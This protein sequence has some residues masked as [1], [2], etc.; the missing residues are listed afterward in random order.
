MYPRIL[1]VDGACGTGDLSRI[2]LKK[3]SR[4]PFS[5]TGMDLSEKMIVR[6]RKKNR[7]GK[8]RFIPGDLENMPFQD[9]QFDSIMIG[10]GIRNVENLSRGLEELFRVLK[11][12][13]S[14]YIL[15]FS[16]PD[17]GCWHHIFR[18]Y[19][20]RILPGIGRIV[21]GHK[22]AYSYLPQSVDRF[23]SPGNFKKMLEKAGFKTVSIQPASGGICTF[24]QSIKPT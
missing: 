11:K 6:A 14:L 16:V 13:G 17:K 3:Y 24:Y 18:F 7:D 12:R 10:F 22:H 1:R 4:V 5:I 19:F 15:E 2:L 20:H 9:E 23:P 21:S 8:V